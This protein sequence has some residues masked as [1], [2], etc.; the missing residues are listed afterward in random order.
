MTWSTLADGRGGQGASG[1]VTFRIGRQ[2][3]GVPVLLVQEVLSGQEVTPVPLS[4]PEV[5]GFLNLRGQIVTAVDL[6][7]VLGLPGRDKAAP[8]MNVVVRQDDELYALVVDEVGDVLE[9]GEG[10]VVPAPR[11]LDRV[12]K[13]RSLGVVRMESGLLVVL[14]VHALLGAGAAGTD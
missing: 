7:A 6:R 9:V 12:W 1:F 8:F 11:T 3:L 13:D 4:P 14:D 10:S 5:E 2:W